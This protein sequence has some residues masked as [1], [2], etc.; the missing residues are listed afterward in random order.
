[1]APAGTSP[2]FTEV[3][4]YDSEI[5]TPFEAKVSFRDSFELASDAFDH[6]LKW[7]VAHAGVY[8]YPLKSINNPCNCEFL[9]EQD[10][11]TIVDKLALGVSV[12]LPSFKAPPQ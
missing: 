12:S 9:K 3:L 1:M 4:I 7:V 2:F 5:S 11:Q 10:Q 6:A 8:K